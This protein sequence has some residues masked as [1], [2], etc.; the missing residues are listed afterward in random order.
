MEIRKELERL[1]RFMAIEKLLDKV[2]LATEILPERVTHVLP[3]IAVSN[4]GLTLSRLLLVTEN[5]LCDV[6]IEGP[7]TSSEFDF[8]A[9]GSIRNYRFNVWTQELKEGDVVK[10]SYDVAEI[11]LI[12]DPPHDF[13]TDLSYAGTERAAWLKQVVDGIPLTL[14]LGAESAS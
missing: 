14:I 4:D 1:T 11:T 10:A 6:R 12:H 8:V 2:A 5:F 9:K 13:R 7:Q 3:S